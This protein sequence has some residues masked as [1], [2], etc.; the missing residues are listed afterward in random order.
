MLSLCVF[1]GDRRISM[2]TWGRIS[3]HV[4]ERVFL[5]WDSW[6]WLTNESRHESVNGVF[7]SATN[8]GSRILDLDLLQSIQMFLQGMLPEKAQ[9]F[10]ASLGLH[11]LACRSE[12]FLNAR[13]DQLLV[14]FGG[15]GAS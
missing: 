1:L 7:S 3:A 2:H 8:L 6:P 5:P 9:C 15:P 14:C 13:D 10:D 11:L 4:A 12:S